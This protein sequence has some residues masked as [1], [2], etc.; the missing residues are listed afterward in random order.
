[1]TS[2]VGARDTRVHVLTYRI[3]QIS[4]DRK[5]KSNILFQ[6]GFLLYPKFSTA[7]NYPLY[8]IKM[9]FFL[10]LSY[11]KVSA[12]FTYLGRGGHL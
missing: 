3:M 6:E 10:K 2:F 1:M 9:E 11:S 4:N 8:G 5:K 12:F 7:E